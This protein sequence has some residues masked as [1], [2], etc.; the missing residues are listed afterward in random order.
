MRVPLCLLAILA[1]ACDAGHVVIDDPTSRDDIVAETGA[2]AADTYDTDTADTSADPDSDGP[3]CEP[4]AWVDA[5][6]LVMRVCRPSSDVSVL[7]LDEEGAEVP[8]EDVTYTTRTGLWRV[9]IPEGAVYVA[10]W[11]LHEDG[12]ETCLPSP[13]SCD[14][15]SHLAD[16]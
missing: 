14:M 8:S 9:E 5:D 4:S 1:F 12:S 15:A 11:F 3:D 6:Y 7:F 10:A 13:D 16:L 2:G